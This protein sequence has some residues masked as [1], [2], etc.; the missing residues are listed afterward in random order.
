MDCGGNFSRLPSV[1]GFETALASDVSFSP[2]PPGMIA[3]TW[4]STRATANLLDCTL[5]CS[6]GRRHIIPAAI[7][8]EPSRNICSFST[9]T[10]ASQ[11]FFCC[12]QES[13]QNAEILKGRSGI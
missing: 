8:R 12:W 11:T 10:F 5:N 6:G 3:E 1:V 9:R 4:R 13:L 7:L 2:D